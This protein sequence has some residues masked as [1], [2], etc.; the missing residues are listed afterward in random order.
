MRLK[1]KKWLFLAILALVPILSGCE[2]CQKKYVAPPPAPIA[3][4]NLSAAAASP[5]QINLDW[6]DNSTTEEG[7]YVDRR[8]TGDYERVAILS[9]NATSYSDTGLSA[10]TTYWYKVT[11][12]N[13]GGE[14]DPS[15]EASATTPGEPPPPPEPLE[16]PTEVR[17]DVVS[18]KLVLLSWEDNS[19]DE[20][21]FKVRCRM[22]E[23]V[24]L[25]IATL[26]PDSTFFRHDFL[27]PM[28]AL[29][30]YVEVYRGDESVGS[31]PAYAT[32]P[33]PIE[34]WL[35]RVTL[36]SENLVNVNAGFRFIPDWSIPGPPETE[37]CLI[38]IST[39][40]Y[41]NPSSHPERK[42]VGSLE[43]TL[44]LYELIY[45]SGWWWADI[46]VPIVGEVQGPYASIEITDV[47]IL[48]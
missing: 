39:S 14:S 46:E 30:Y 25:T 28:T 35:Y 2:G 7:F 40:V 12:Y 42:L 43:T 24:Y 27:Q 34:V 15:N 41:D 16:P 36:L 45:A 10:E 33:N 23:T 19:S 47:E 6:Q 4:S 38:E 8:I 22:N 13:D 44:E 48:Y 32:T 20:D 5:N 1:S 17:A 11:A 9:A 3:P 18:Y 29:E 26:G 37:P 21:G 31:E